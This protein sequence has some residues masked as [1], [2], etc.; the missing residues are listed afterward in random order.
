MSFPGVDAVLPAPTVCYAWAAS[1]YP[2]QKWQRDAGGEPPRPSGA[3][4]PSNTTKQ[5]DAI[6]FTI[7][8]AW[9]CHA[10]PPLH[11]GG[12]SLPKCIQPSSVILPSAAAQY[13]GPGTGPGLQNSPFQWRRAATGALRPT[14]HLSLGE[15]WV[16]RHAA[17]S[18]V[19]DLARLRG[20]SMS[21]PRYTPI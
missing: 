14:T 5:N 10:V 11:K 19:T 9:L 2:F 16:Q 21:Q 18:T 7:P 13:D 17:Y 4:A 20:L 12:F 8:P 3:A 1:S 6:S 15:F